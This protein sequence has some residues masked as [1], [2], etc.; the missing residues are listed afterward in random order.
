MDRAIDRTQLQLRQSAVFV[1][2]I[3]DVA[4][5]FAQESGRVGARV[6]R[7]PSR[8][9]AVAERAQIVDAENMVGVRVGVK[10]RIHARDALANRLRIEIGR[11]IDEHHL[12]RV[13]EHH[14]RPGAAVVRIA[15]M[16]D[17]AVATQR[18]HAHRCA[19]AQHFM[20][21]CAPSWRRKWPCQLIV[22]WFPWP[23][24]AAAD[25]PARWSL[26][27]RPCALRRGCF[28]GNFLPWM[29]GCLWFFPPSATAYRSS[30]ALR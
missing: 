7:Q 8:L 11:G 6:E 28:A 23:L 21:E 26:P 20:C 3:E 1:I 2:G 12:A 17:G 5:H 24:R 9:V 18:G 19:A 4:E 27:R 22:R 14:R 15:G 25:A 30:A 16:A 29:S 13:L 10:H